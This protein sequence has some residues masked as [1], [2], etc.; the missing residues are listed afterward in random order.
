M[1]LLSSNPLFAFES[2][3][4]YVRKCSRDKFITDRPHC[5]VATVWVR[6]TAAVTVLRL[7]PTYQKI[8]LVYC[9][10]RYIWIYVF[11]AVL[12]CIDCKFLGYCEI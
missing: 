3:L 7:A 9:Y 4:S 1:F 10:E 5:D 11:C 12:F 8:A 2:T 6:G